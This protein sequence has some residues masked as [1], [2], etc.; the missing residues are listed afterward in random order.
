[1]SFIGATCSNAFDEEI[2]NTSN[3][4]TWISLDSSNYTDLVSLDSSNYTSNV[5]LDSSNYTDSLSLDS[6]NY[7]DSVSLHFS[8][9][10][11]RIEEESSDRIGFPASLFPFTV[12]PG[13]YIRIK[14]QELEFAQ[15][16]QLVGLHTAAIRGIE[17]QILGLIGVEG[18]E[19]GLRGG[20]I[21]TAGN[22]Y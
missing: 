2:Q 1:M 7:T 19:V 14:T 10:T 15:V 22:A 20:A 8:N 16:S 21:A 12:Q 9:Y 13:V 18:A 4:A 6:S 11:E 3:Y 5:S 17:E